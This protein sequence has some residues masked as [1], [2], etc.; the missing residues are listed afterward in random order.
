MQITNDHVDLRNT[1]FSPSPTYI[2]NGLTKD[3]LVQ[4]F[5][6]GCGASA[7][8]IRH[9]EEV[10]WGLLSGA[11]QGAGIVFHSH[12]TAVGWAKTFGADNEQLC[13]NLPAAVSGT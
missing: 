12:V 7:H 1:H 8:D 10:K 13:M 6:A 9:L 11:K 3:P 5:T 2:I 4:E